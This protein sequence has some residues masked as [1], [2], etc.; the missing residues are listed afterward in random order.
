MA[1]Y[2]KYIEEFLQ[3]SLISIAGKSKYSL[4]K[5]T[6]HRIFLIKILIEN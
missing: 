4:E 5:Y 1:P 6:E 3:Y 2:Y